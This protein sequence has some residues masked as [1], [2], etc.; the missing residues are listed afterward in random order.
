MRKLPSVLE[1]PV[2]MLRIEPRHITPMRTG[3]M[4]DNTRLSPIRSRGYDSPSLKVSPR[5]AEV[6]KLPKLDDIT[7]K[8]DDDMKKDLHPEVV[9]YIENLEN[10]EYRIYNKGTNMTKRKEI[11]TKNRI[12]IHDR[13]VEQCSGR[14]RSP[15]PD[16]TKLCDP[17]TSLFNEPTFATGSRMSQNSV[18]MTRKDDL[19]RWWH[20]SARNEQA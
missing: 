9:R 4:K 12:G 11:L 6:R 5:L 10:K 1:K 3:M 19:R 13:A 8:L 2:D 20:S 17:R 15:S 18:Y 16:L 7:T 14:S